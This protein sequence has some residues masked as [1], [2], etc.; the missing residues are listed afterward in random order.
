MA[1]SQRG[2]MIYVSATCLSGVVGLNTGF[3][4]ATKTRCPHYNKLSTSSKILEN[5]C[6]I[7]I[8]GASTMMGAFFIPPIVLSSPIWYTFGSPN[9][10]SF[11]EFWKW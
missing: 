10:R 6:S 11:L 4:I 3:N 5:I 1:L 2:K 9:T 7:S 8:I